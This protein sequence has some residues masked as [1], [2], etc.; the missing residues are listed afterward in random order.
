[1]EQNDDF[2][3]VFVSLDLVQKRTEV[4][5]QLKY[6]QAQTEPIVKCFEDPEFNNQIQTTRLKD[7]FLVTWWLEF[8]YNLKSE[9]LI[10]SMLLILF[11]LCFVGMGDHS[12]NT[13][14]KTMV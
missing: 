10:S 2:F 11:I 3:V 7:Y 4:V 14:K 12:S 5:T 9:N 13:L 6:L 1:M 8:S